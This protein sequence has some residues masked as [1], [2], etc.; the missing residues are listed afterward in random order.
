TDGLPSLSLAV[1]VPDPNIMKAKPRGRK[2]SMMSEILIFS[3]IAGIIS[4]FATMT[5]FL[6]NYNDLA[7]ARTLALTV[8]VIFELFQVFVSRTPDGISVFRYN[9]LK[10]KFLLGSVISA[11]LLQLVIIYTPAAAAIFHF[12]P[13]SLSEWLIMFGIVIAGITLLDI[14]RLIQHKISKRKS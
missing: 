11:F 5:L 6:T 9:P 3:I 7:K 14:T 10:N 12:A 8:S 2:G 13:L 1:D 4:Y